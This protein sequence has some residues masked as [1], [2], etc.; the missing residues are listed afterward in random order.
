MRE[1]RW[2]ERIWG[3]HWQKYLPVDS[4]Q[5]KGPLLYLQ[6]H[7]FLIPSVFFNHTLPCSPLK[8]IYFHIIYPFCCFPQT[9]RF[10]LLTSQV[11]M[12]PVVQLR[13]ESLCRESLLGFSKISSCQFLVYGSS[14]HFLSISLSKTHSS[15]HRGVMVRLCT[16]F[17]SGEVG[18]AIP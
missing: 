18:T 8:G 14:P 3:P 9:F 10:V 17:N 11:N 1:F 2:L 6:S 4:E 13:R 5:E 7:I 16:S 12:F 15:L